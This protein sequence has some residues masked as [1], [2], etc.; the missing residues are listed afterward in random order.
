MEDFPVNFPPSFNVTSEQI[1][2]IKDWEVGEKYRLVIEVEQKS[3]AENDN[4]IVD[5]RFEIVSYKTIEDDDSV[6]EKQ[7]AKALSS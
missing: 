6:L 1:P 4:K 2:E 7:Q 5:S 3:K